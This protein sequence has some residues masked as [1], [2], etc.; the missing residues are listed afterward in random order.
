MPITPAHA[1]VALPFVRTP[2]VPAAIAIGAMAP[3]LPLFLRGF[4]PS[5]GFT[6]SVD[7]ISWTALIALALLLLWRLVL[8]PALVLLAPDAIAGRLPDAW[9]RT[10]RTALT[11]LLA[12][13]ESFGYPLL[14]IVS[15]VLG[16][17]SHITWDLF[18]HEGRWGVQAIPLLQ[19]A[20]GPLPGYS[21]LQH[22]SGVMGLLA[23]AVF[24]TLWLRRRQAVQR[25]RMLPAWVRWA[26]Y[27]TLPAF[28]AAGWLAGLA[29]YGPVTEA[30]TLQHL[31]YRT[32]PPAIGAWGAMTLLLC[33][34][35][36]PAAQRRSTG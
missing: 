28:L 30:F 27:A 11:E 10:G 33:A 4:G 15:L 29:A 20:W 6:H 7:N 35:I 8:R 24:A 9:G 2:L 22:G 12:P 36:V 19:Q 3:D 18:T 16:V 25:P 1:V 26:W 23:L 32:L 21:W 31:A 13:R 34:V 17:L 14:L 5:Y